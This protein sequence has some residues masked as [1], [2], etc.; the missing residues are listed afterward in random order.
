MIDY[1]DDRA[2]VEGELLALRDEVEV[3]WEQ[4]LQ[5]ADVEACE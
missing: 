3:L 1:W 5:W 4:R 2:D